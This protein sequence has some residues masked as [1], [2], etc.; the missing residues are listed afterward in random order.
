ME[1]EKFT[2]LE[3]EKEFQLHLVYN[4]PSWT[5][6]SFPFAFLLDGFHLTQAPERNY[7]TSSPVAPLLPPMAQLPR[8]HESDGALLALCQK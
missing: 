8:C 6:V 4:R 7:E 3:N 5:R 1:N 2:T